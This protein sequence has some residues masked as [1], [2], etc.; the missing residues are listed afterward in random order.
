MCGGGALIHLSHIKCNA[1]VEWRA[2]QRAPRPCLYSSVLC[3]LAVWHEATV[4]LLQTKRGDGGALD[5]CLKQNVL[6]SLNEC[7]NN[8]VREETTGEP[9][10]CGLLIVSINRSLT[11]PFLSLPF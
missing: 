2:L 4:C 10:N 8:F 6:C 5:P 1:S 3:L 7:V 9:H 11:E